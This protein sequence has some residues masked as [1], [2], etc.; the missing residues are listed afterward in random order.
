[1][2]K[3]LISELQENKMTSLFHIQIIWLILPSIPQVLHSAST[4]TSAVHQTLTAF[5]G[6]LLLKQH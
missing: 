5:G 6:R 2:T 3:A 1:M 4:V